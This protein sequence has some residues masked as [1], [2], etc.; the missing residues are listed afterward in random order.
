MTTQHGVDKLAT[1]EIGIRSSI[2]AHMGCY[3]VRDAGDKGAKQF[4]NTS[5]VAH[6]HELAQLSHVRN[7]TR[8]RRVYLQKSCEVESWV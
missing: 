5:G 8:I 3:D 7:R 1:T 6:R 4:S 2:V